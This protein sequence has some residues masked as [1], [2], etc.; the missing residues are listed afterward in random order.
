MA[1]GILYKRGG[2]GGID[3][4]DTTA[5]VDTVL[6]GIEFYDASGNKLTGTFNHIKPLAQTESIPTISSTA[7]AVIV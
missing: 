7:T 5:T 3:I 6:E 1:E 4:S 2:S